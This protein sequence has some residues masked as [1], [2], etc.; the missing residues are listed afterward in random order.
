LIFCFLVGT[1]AGWVGSSLSAQETSKAAEA[2]KTQVTPQAV[3]PGQESPAKAGAEPP[4][5]LV[6]T[7]LS[8]EPL[9]KV[10]QRLYLTASVRVRPE[11]NQNLTDFD[12]SAGDQSEFFSGRFRLGIGADLPFDTGVF[13]EAQNNGTWGDD[14]V[15]GNVDASGDDNVKIYQAFGEARRIGG[16]GFSARVGRQEL[17]YGTEMLLGDADFGPGLSHDTVKLMYETDM[18]S[19]HAW[20]AKEVDQTGI[21][22]ANPFQDNDVDFWGIYS[23]YNCCKGTGLDAYYLYLRDPRSTGT[24]LPDDKRHTL[25]ARG[26]VEPEIQMPVS[27]VLSSE[28]AWQ[29]GYSGLGEHT[30]RAFAWETTA[31][32]VAKDCPHKPKATIG[33]AFASGDHNPNDTRD[34]TFNP[35]FEDNHPRLGYSDLFA[36]SNLHAITI[37]GTLKPFEHIEPGLGYYAFWVH[38]TQDGVQPS[39]VQPGLGANP[40]GN[41]FIGHEVNVFVNFDWTKHLVAQLAWAHLIPGEFIRNQFGSLD[42]ADR[43]YLQLVAGF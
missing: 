33:Y 42:G 5:G 10:I 32:F 16:S 8:G 27:V 34:E 13:I 36:L 1:A 43:V 41:H 26:F 17:L 6:F 12:S 23:T 37:V 4:K 14:S 20:F 38:R 28:F 29:F 3:T 15:S 7:D 18:L 11:Y 22:G 2:A 31:G 40:G 30:V 35:L 9:E 21:P 19:V 25:G 39:S 24:A